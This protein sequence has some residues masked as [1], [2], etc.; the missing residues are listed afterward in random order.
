MVQFNE[1]TEA[2]FE[3]LTSD[4]QWDYLV[5]PVKGGKKAAMAAMRADGRP[6]R[7]YPNGER[8]AQLPERGGDDVP[9]SQEQEQALMEMLKE[10]EALVT[11]QLDEEMKLK[12]KVEK[13]LRD[14]R[15]ELGPEAAQQ[16][17]QQASGDRSRRR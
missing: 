13:R 16:A 15:D 8:T 5:P 2:L 14:L 3:A 1:P 9:F 17:A 11:Q 4:S 7:G 12:E 6:K 10:K